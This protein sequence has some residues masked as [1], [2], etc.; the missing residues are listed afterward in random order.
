MIIL[1]V[2][3]LIVLGVFDQQEILH[4]LLIL[5]CDQVGGHEM[6]TIVDNNGTI[7]IDCFIEGGKY[8]R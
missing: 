2:I 8:E 7:E 5:S 4:P 3:I 6:F 1:I